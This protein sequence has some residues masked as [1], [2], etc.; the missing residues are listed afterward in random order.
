MYK[1]II[2]DLG[3]VLVHFDF[4]RGY[5]ALEGHCP[6]AAAEIPKRIGATDLVER[7][8][9]GLV[10]PREFFAQFS[11]T[12]DLDL[13]YERFCGIWSSIFTELL[14]PEPVIESLA[15]RYRLLL[16]SNTNALHFEMLRANYP[17]LRHFH[18]LILSYQVHA[19]KPRPEIYQAAI[20]HA[21]CRPE[22]IFYTDDIAAYV[23]GA[24]RLGIDAVQFE[25]WEQLEHEM[26]S[27]GILP[28]TGQ[29][30]KNKKRTGR[31]GGKRPVQDL[32]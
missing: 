13:D 12:L 31:L 18:H 8:E 16:L 7:F 9:T 32:L 30:A 25:S 19:M 3:K 5:R 26:K 22:E 4:K 6:Y 1:A 17:V 24:R 14:I 28:A 2:F 29:P 20:E 15:S 27:R 21:G 10:E 11:R 23:E